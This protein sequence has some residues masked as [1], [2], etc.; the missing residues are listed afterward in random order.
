[1]Y[2]NNSV[3]PDRKNWLSQREIQFEENFLR[4]SSENSS[5]AA[6]PFVNDQNKS[7][8][9]QQ[10]RNR[11]FQLDVMEVLGLSFFPFLKIGR[12]VTGRL[13]WRAVLWWPLPVCPYARVPGNRAR[14]RVPVCPWIG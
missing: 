1:M 13:Q 10:C 14:A 9:R 3:K 7:R 6:E 4:P 12:Y 2:T 5:D 8:L 11:K